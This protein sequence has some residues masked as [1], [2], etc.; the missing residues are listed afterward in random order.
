MTPRSSMGRFSGTAQK[1]GIEIRERKSGA[2]RVSVI[3]SRLPLTFT[4]EGVLALPACTVSAPRDVARERR[5]GRL[6]LGVEGPLDRTTEA[7]RRYGT[8]VREAEARP[9][10][11]RVRQ[12]LVAD[13]RHAPRDL[14]HKPRAGRTRLVRVRQEPGAGHR[15]QAPAEEVVV[16]RRVDVLDV[17]VADVEPQDAGRRRPSPDRQRGPQ[18]GD[19]H[20]RSESRRREAETESPSHSDPLLSFATGV[21]AR[22]ANVR[23]HADRCKS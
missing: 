17:G 18:H 7:P 20:R 11:E 10:P 5:G 3:A 14:G 4:P 19:E 2:G 13:P 23:P 1:K 12:P 21:C 6:H 8:P 15:L 9:D 16:Q 22:R